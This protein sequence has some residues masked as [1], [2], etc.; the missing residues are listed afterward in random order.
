MSKTKKLLLKKKQKGISEIIALILIILVSVV[1]IAI[2]IA[3]SKNSVKEKLD[4]STESLKQ[5]SSTECINNSLSIDEVLV[6][7]KNKNV[8][9]LVSNNSNLKY[10]NLV[11]TVESV[12]EDGN[13][14]KAVGSFNKIIKPGE[15]KTYDT[16]IDFNFSKSN[17]DDINFLGITDIYLTNGTCPNQ[18]IDLK[19]YDVACN[20]GG[21]GTEE[22]PFMIC[23]AEDLFNIRNDLTLYYKQGK[24][25]D[26]GTTPY[27]EEGGFTPIGDGTINFTGT[28]NGN[29]YKIKSLYIYTERNNYTGLFGFASNANIE[30]VILED[31]NIAGSGLVGALV[32]ATDGTTI[33][34]CRSSGNLTNNSER[35]GGLVGQTQNSTIV[36]SYSTVNVIGQGQVGGLV[37]NN[38]SSTITNSY[39]TGTVTGNNYYT[40]GLVGVNNMATIT[41]SYSTESVTGY[42]IVGGFVGYNIGG[43]IVDSYATGAVDGTDTVGGFVGLN[44]SSSISNSYS[45]GRVNADNTSGGLVGINQYSTVSGSFYNSQTSGQS[46]DEGKGSPQTTSWMK[47]E[48]NYIDSGWDFTHYWDITEGS[49]YP[50]LLPE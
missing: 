32:G 34:N 14:T 28:L 8:N 23:T 24:N 30:N 36:D 16:T 4:I 22:E 47:T 19:G 3:W 33:S 7:T 27:N 35:S 12:D 17:F 48:Q 41:N 25:I 50:F 20:S 10:F 11:L 1:L 5:A 6:N 26:L 49:S 46:D 29:G 9:I 21:T 39:S 40:G 45:I 37:G 18:A 2:I 43:T 44:E 42:N 13:Q 38:N 31:V 15:V